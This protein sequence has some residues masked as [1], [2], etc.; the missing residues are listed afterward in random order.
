MVTILVLKKSDFNICNALERHLNRQLKFECNML[1]YKPEL[2]ILR[3][4][5]KPFVDILNV[6]LKISVLN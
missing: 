5:N 1:S 2:D 4:I 6:E 3:Y